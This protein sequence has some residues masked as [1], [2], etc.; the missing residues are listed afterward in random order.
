[1]ITGA[2]NVPRPRNEPVLAYAPGSPER[3]AVRVQLEKMVRE[4][5]Q[6]TARIG[7][8]RVATGDTVEAVMPHDY[9][10][11]LAIWHRAGA[12]EVQDA[13]D[14]ALEARQSWACMPW[15]D[16]AAIFLKAAELLAGPYRMVLNAATMLGQS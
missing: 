6:I 13:I 3:N 4:V 8:R 9:R 5:I 12:E 10:H 11:V 16:R 14:A 2:F 7:G 1:M 15:H